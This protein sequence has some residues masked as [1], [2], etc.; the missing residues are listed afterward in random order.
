MV[1]TKPHQHQNKVIVLSTIF[2]PRGSVTTT[3]MYITEEMRMD[4]RTRQEW[5]SLFFVLGK[6]EHAVL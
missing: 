4:A 6:K 2:E 3:P 5:Q 1:T